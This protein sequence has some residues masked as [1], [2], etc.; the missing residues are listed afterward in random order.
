MENIFKHQ[1]IFGK[2][3]LLGAVAV[4]MILGS[5]FWLTARINDI[6]REK[7]QDL[8]E[9]LV[10][11]TVERV[12]AS[13]ADYAHWDLAHNI[14]KARADEQILEHLGSG[15]TDSDLFDQVLIL[16]ADGQ[17]AYVFDDADNPTDPDAIDLAAIKPF[18]DA[19][20]QHVPSAYIAVSGIGRINGTYGA[21]AAAWITPDDSELAS[22]G[23]L[24]IMVGL[25]LFNND[26][27]NAIQELTQ[28]TG[29]AI[30]EVDPAKAQPSVGL[31]GPDGQPVA[32]LVWTPQDLGTILRTEVMPGILAV[33]L[34]I[35]AI[36]IS[37]ARYFHKQSQ[38]LER[39]RYVACNDQLTGLLNRSGLDGV[40]SKPAVR[41]RIASGD[42][43]LIYLDLNDFKKLNDEH[44]HKDGDRALK[45][46]ARRLMATVRDCDHVVRLG[47]D[48]FLCL[49]L[50]DK[51]AIA[52]DSVARQ[53]ADAFTQAIEFSSHATV[54]RPSIGVAVSSEGI[55]WTTLI[56]QADAAMYLAKRTHNDAPM[57]FS[58]D[59]AKTSNP[60]PDAET[61]AA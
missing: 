19:L 27:L 14:V 49:I 47:G 25:V 2:L 31:T 6:E 16:S 58:A 1:F 42:V 7:T 4:G 10:T 57:Y 33:C 44:G 21:V 32:Q 46:T 50:D 43:A 48:E 15:A 35:L 11:Q 26:K 23:D 51:P 22:S 20:K 34:G 60:T 37:A 18:L 30:R 41:R 52:A 28:S 5:L 29:Y 38:M 39:A 55:D 17:I 53:I 45:V 61:A 40:L 12:R 54:L 3:F 59:I 9:L 13:T 24:P 36:C 56:N 8:V